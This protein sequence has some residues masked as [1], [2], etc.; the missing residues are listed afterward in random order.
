M[1]KIRRILYTLGKKKISQIRNRIYGT[2]CTQPNV[3][4]TV[5]MYNNFVIW[6]LKNE[7]KTAVRAHFP[8]FNIKLTT[9]EEHYLPIPG[10]P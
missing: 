2:Q 8:R 1:W 9:W 7:V 4:K 5:G 3:L 6:K 10:V